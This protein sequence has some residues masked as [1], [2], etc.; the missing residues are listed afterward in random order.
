M[1]WSI[2]RAP[3]GLVSRRGIG[4]RNAGVGLRDARQPD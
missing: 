4:L 2:R 3:V 1:S